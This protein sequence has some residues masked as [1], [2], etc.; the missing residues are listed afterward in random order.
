MAEV[1]L[2]AG[3]YMERKDDDKHDVNVVDMLRAEIG[4]GQA[5]EVPPELPEVGS[6]HTYKRIVDVRC[7][8]S[9]V[10]LVPSWRPIPKKTSKNFV[11]M[12]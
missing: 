11:M 4:D 7:D 2:G 5:D 10:V 1:N 3:F 9:H 6:Q 12:E 8:A